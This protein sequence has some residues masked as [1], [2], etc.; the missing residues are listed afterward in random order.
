MRILFEASLALEESV[1]DQAS[2]Q[3]RLSSLHCP[4]LRPAGT[5]ALP[6]G[7]FDGAS[8]CPRSQQEFPAEDLEGLTKS[9][10]GGGAVVVAVA[11][12]VVFVIAD[13]G[14]VV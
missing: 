5:R 14:V 1:G 2:E 3:L 6:S 11:V 7:P 9:N 13:A 10:G 12:V 8:S 4:D